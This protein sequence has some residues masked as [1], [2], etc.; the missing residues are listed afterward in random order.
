MEWP[1]SLRLSIMLPDYEEVI[2]PNV[3]VWIERGIQGGRIV[4]GSLART[5]QVRV[6][7]RYRILV[8]KPT[9]PP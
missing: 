9:L 8:D 2:T 1:E 6:T 7:S 4:K 3:K 5:P